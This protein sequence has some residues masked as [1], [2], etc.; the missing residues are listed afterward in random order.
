MMSDV[1]NLYRYSV[2]CAQ[3]PTG[4]PSTTTPWLDFSCQAP[5]P[6]STTL[7]G[8][9]AS[10]SSVVT[11]ASTA[12][13]ER[14]DQVSGPGIS[15]TVFVG[16][17]V[18]NTNFSLSYSTWQSDPYYAGTG[19]GSGTFSFSHVRTTENYRHDQPTEAYFLGSGNGINQL[20]Q[21]GNP[22]VSHIN[23]ARSSR[24]PKST[25]CAGTKFV[26]Y[27]RDA[28]SWEAWD[29]GTTA[30]GVH[31]QNNTDPACLPNSA[32]LSQTQLKAIFVTCTITNWSQVGGQN[33]PMSI[34]TAQ[35]GSGTR[36]TFDG[37]V[38][39]SSDSCIP[40]AQK[41]THIIPENS[42]TP[43][44]AAGDT[45]GAIYPFSFGV[46][47]NQ[48]H[49][50]GGALLG[51]VDGVTPSSSSISDLSFPWGRYLYNV[52]CNSSCGNPN[53][54]ATQ[55]TLDY[56]GEKGWICKI[57]NEHSVNPITGR[58]YHTDLYF[59][60]TAN[61]FVPIPA[62]TIGGG[63]TGGDYCRLFP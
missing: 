15:G 16:D 8:T 42:N 26:A 20:C 18:A 60:Y 57:G 29:D 23:F 62:G 63:A 41:A 43:I 3:I 22:G 32:C 37:F 25:D 34:Y 2:G 9:S 1:D 7:T 59:T 55:A 54:V 47:S 56:V 28:I 24:G 35:A 45:A 5:D 36:S 44:T 51:A 40:S 53:A 50:N 46:W 48:V 38:G 27:A 58:N 49:G 39:G 61:G 17:I 6:V 10:G 4:L 13:L 12:G 11:A 19:A 52:Y 33:V 14:G 21:Q 30:S 31:A